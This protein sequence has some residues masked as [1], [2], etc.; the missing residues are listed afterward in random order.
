MPPIELIEISEKEMVE[1]IST[2]DA[3]DT[4]AWKVR[5]IADAILKLVDESGNIKRDIKTA[6]KQ[7][8]KSLE[9][10]ADDSNALGEAYLP[11][12]MDHNIKMSQK[13]DNSNAIL[14]AIKEMSINQSSSQ[15]DANNSAILDAI[16]DMSLNQSV[17]Q[18]DASALL[19]AIHEVSINQIVA[20]TKP[21]KGTEDIID[22]IKELNAKQDMIIKE[23]KTLKQTPV[24]NQISYAN[25]VTTPK[26]VKK[27]TNIPK[28]SA[29]VVVY[30]KEDANASATDTR[31]ELESKLKASEFEFPVLQTKNLSKGKVLVTLPDAKSQ[32][33]FA[34]AT[35]KIPSLE[36]QFARKHRPVILLKGV[37]KDIKDDAIINAIANQKEIKDYLSNK[38]SKNA[39][40]IK[41][42][43]KANNRQNEQHL[44]NVGVEVDPAIRIIIMKSTDKRISIEYQ[45]VHAED[46]NPLKQCY[47]CWGFGHTSKDCPKRQTPCCPHCAGEHRYA[48]CNKMVK[49]ICC[50]NCK[51]SNARLVVL[52][53]VKHQTPTNHSSRS[54]ACPHLVRM[55]Q[56]AK[57]RVDYGV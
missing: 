17:S 18:T 15:T 24:A 37:R 5:L 38:K 1:L 29:S 42:R 31:R 13:E 36:T 48:D 26:L 23:I 52:G 30:L 43:F 46:A 9:N 25:A 54:N 35:A 39:H 7:Q 12:G 2:K 53:K 4:I 3:L 41:L 45:R 22:A 57:E 16:K 19:D 51:S 14:D 34:N 44:M 56:L 10:I 47:N 8:C 32:K 27:Q 6:I 21:P 28:G 40:A 11:C 49:D 20:E 33:T 50:V 55:S